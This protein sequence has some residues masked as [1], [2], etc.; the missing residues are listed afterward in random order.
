MASKVPD[1][2]EE[3]WGVAGPP[4]DPVDPKDHSAWRR[5]FKPE[6]LNRFSERE[7]QIYVAAIRRY[8][9]WGQSLAIKETGF[10]A[11]TVKH[12][13]KH[14]PVFAEAVTQAMNE[15]HECIVRRLVGEAVEGHMEPIWVKVDGKYQKIGDRKILETGM[16]TKILQSH[17]SFREKQEL[18]VNVRGGVLVAPAVAS[19]EEWDAQF[20]PPPTEDSASARPTDDD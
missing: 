16:R 4:P 19:E 2:Q 18:D 13:L 7:K 9:K 15:H 3:A 12:W 11:G 5:P 8:G 20:Q 14:D 10:S 17:P 6:S 1:E